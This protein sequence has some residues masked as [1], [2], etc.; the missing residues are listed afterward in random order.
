MRKEVIGGTNDMDNPKT[1]TRKVENT[2]RRTTLD[3]RETRRKVYRIRLDRWPCH[4]TATEKK[5]CFL[6]G[7]GPVTC[8]ACPS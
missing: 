6:V 3:K 8:H 7:C 2:D 1:R 5:A 4:V